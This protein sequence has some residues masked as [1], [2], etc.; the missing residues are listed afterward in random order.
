M[1]RKLVLSAVFFSLCLLVSGQLIAQ[2]PLKYGASREGK[3]TDAAMQRWRENRFGQFIHFGLYSLAGGHWNGKYVEGAAEWIKGNARISDEDYEA[4]TRQFVLPEF[5]ARE[6]ARI[7][8]EMGVKYS[9]ITTKHHEGFCLWPSEYTDYDVSRTPFGR[10]LLKEYVD[11]YTQEGIDV[12]F[13]YSIIDWNHPDWRSRVETVE[14]SLAFFRYCDFMNKQITELMT[15]YPEVK[16]FWFDG[17]WD[18]SV[19]KFGKITWDIEQLMHRLNPGIICGSRLRVDEKGARHFDTNGKLMGDYEQGWERSLPEKA[20]Q[21]DWECV[22]TIP[23]NQ[24]GYQADWRGHIKSATEIIEM[25]AAATSMNGNFVLNFGPKGD[26]SLREEEKQMARKVGKWMQINGEAI[27]GC[28]QAP[29]KPQKWGYYTRHRDNGFVYMVVCYQPVSGM[30]KVV[31]PTG[32][33]IE[34]CV[35]LGKEGMELKPEKS[36]KNEFVIPAPEVKDGFPYVIR[37]KLKEGDSV[38]NYVAP[39]V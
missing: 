15:R 30:L 26:G 38:G 16:G 20:P 25:L 11:A 22:M 39:K 9:V 3:R 23:E 35:V 21:N 10:D 37:L 34:N 29:L 8:K 24:W 31:L 17:T 32:S 36:T 1:R 6:W 2:I 14:D 5:D 28:A 12:Y 18:K 13:Y 27:Y 19:V 4:L 33:V 7:A